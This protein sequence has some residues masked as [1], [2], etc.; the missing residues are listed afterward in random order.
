MITILFLAS[1][2]S[3]TGRLNVSREARAIKER[4]RATP[5]STQF[6]IEQEESLRV[7]DLSAA[8]LRHA[9]QIVHFTGH[10]DD[11]GALV[12]EDDA[13]GAVLVDQD[14]VRELFEE[15]AKEVKCVV[16][17]ACYTESQA[18]QIARHVDCVVGMRAEISDESAIDFAS[19]FYQA[20]GF[21]ESVGRA[22]RLGKI[23]A[24]LA[25]AIDK[26]VPMLLVRDGVDAEKM[27]FGTVAGSANA[28]DSATTTDVTRVRSR[29]TTPLTLILFA[30]TLTAAVIGGLALR[31]S[32][33][34]TTDGGPDMVKPTPAP[35]PPAGTAKASNT[36]ASAAP[37]VVSVAALVPKGSGE[38]ALAPNAKIRS[39]AKLAFRV[40]TSDRAY[41]YVVQKTRKGI[42]PL[43]P[44]QATSMS[45]PLSALTSLRIPSAD[46]FTLVDDG[47]YGPLGVTVIASRHELTNLAAAIGSMDAQ[48]GEPDQE[49][50]ARVEKFINSVAEP[51]P[52]SPR[53]RGLLLP[54]KA[55]ERETVSVRY[56][57]RPGDDLVVAAFDLMQVK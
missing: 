23:E 46:Y 38:H 50:G 18:R 4:L 45:N 56:E 8:F 22:F 51:G 42:D 26:D 44:G 29:R 14:A 47:L 30:L 25:S 9:P 57:Q 16:L 36:P 49:A 5:N 6:R 13:S 24:G 12:L 15:F 21:G 31:H 33:R 53:K 19:A 48:H 27:A 7:R 40:Q 55:H 1:N 3:E 34:P 54:P 20:I 37:L 35:Q 10:G 52:G 39:G 32:M 41:V 11:S 28:P 17:N 2:P 43:F